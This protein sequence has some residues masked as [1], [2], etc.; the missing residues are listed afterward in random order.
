MLTTIFFDCGGT[1]FYVEPPANEVWARSCRELGLIVTKKDLDEHES[2]FDAYDRAHF[3]IE[4]EGRYFEE[5]HI[6]AMNLL[7][8]KITCE[9]AGA[10][11]EYFNMNLNVIKFPEVDETLAG[12]KKK[13]MRLAVISNAFPN[14]RQKLRGL[15]IEGYF[16]DIILSSEVGFPKPDRRI[17]EVALA[18]LGVAPEES[19]YVGDSYEKDIIGAKNAGMK[20]VLVDRLKESLGGCEKVETLLGVIDKIDGF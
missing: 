20:T 14:Q 15:D 1:L 4:D 5:F 6:F 11:Q 2:A 3:P 10:M 12:L 8:F 18:K 19:L 13:G 9:D 17:F 7:G 16:E